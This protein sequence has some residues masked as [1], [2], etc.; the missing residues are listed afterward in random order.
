MIL[1]ET[2]SDRAAKKVKRTMNLMVRFG[3]A[4]IGK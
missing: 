4:S 2:A 3:K 1:G